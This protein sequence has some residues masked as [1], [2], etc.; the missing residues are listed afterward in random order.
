MNFLIYDH[1]QYYKYP[2]IYAHKLCI[3]TMSLTYCNNIPKFLIRYI[4]Q[5]NVQIGKVTI[6]DII[7]C[8]FNSWCDILIIPFFFLLLHF[9]IYTLQY[10]DCVDWCLSLKWSCQIQNV[11]LIWCLA[12]VYDHQI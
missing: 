3:V 9:L 11:M 12:S 4:T 5:I 7:G 8:L 2:E 6:L 1:I 10:L